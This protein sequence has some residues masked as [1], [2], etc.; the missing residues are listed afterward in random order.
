ME[1][2]VEATDVLNTHLKHEAMKPPKG[3]RA[4][5]DWLSGGTRWGA[6]PLRVLCELFATTARNRRHGPNISSIGWA[7]D[8]RAA[9]CR[10]SSTC[11]KGPGIDAKHKHHTHTRPAAAAPAWLCLYIESSAAMKLSRADLI[12]R[13]RPHSLCEHSPTTCTSIPVSS[14][15]SPN[16]RQTAAHNS[17]QTTTAPLLSSR[18]CPQ[19]SPATTPRRQTSST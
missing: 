11:Q 8:L 4:W 16:T 7:H 13:P 19:H 3:R 5:Y 18:A 6:S 9:Y 10:L 12:P 17:I 1:T 15:L 14:H 2:D